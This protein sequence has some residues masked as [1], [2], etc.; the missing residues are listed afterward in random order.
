MSDLAN[1]YDAWYSELSRSE[2]DPRELK[3]CDWILDLLNAQPKKSLLDVA[4]GTGTF[5]KRAEARGLA[6]SGVDV[7]PVAIETAAKRIPTATVRVAR[8][9]E[10]PFAEG[11]FDYVTCI[12]SLEHFPDPEAGAA[13]IRRVLS[14]SGRAAIY[15]PNLFFLG[16][17]YL[18][19]RHGTQPSEGNQEFSERFLTSEGWRG[20]LESQGLA[21]EACHPWN[22]IWAT[23]KVS[24][25]TIAAWNATSWLLPKNL[26]YSFAFVCRR[27]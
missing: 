8:A 3:A 21:V 4:C 1:N 6:V 5:L 27:T 15:V 25:L 11:A 7:S 12:G 20:L 17:I 26:A 2:G 16:H 10:L 19:L 9:E 18:G 23:A 14:P 22:H 24:R 13:E